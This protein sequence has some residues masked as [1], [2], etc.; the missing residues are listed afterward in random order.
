MRYGIENP[1]LKHQYTLFYINIHCHRQW[2]WNP[3][4]RNSVCQTCDFNQKRKTL[5]LLNCASDDIRSWSGMNTALSIVKW[6]VIFSYI[7]S[8]G[9]WIHTKSQTN[10]FVPVPCPWWNKTLR[11]YEYCIVIENELVLN[12]C[13]KMIRRKRVKRVKSRKLFHPL[14]S[15]FWRNLKKHKCPEN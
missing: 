12:I 10:V 13:G 4:L 3:N 5:L 6:M 15:S 14:L 1:Y 11:I 7:T 8:L 9:I 2:T